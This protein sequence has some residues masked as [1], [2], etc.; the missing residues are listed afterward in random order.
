MLSGHES[1]CTIPREKIV[2][3]VLRHAQMGNRIIEDH[4]SLLDDE[5][6]SNKVGGSAPTSCFHFVFQ[7]SIFSGVSGVKGMYILYIYLLK[8]V[9]IHLGH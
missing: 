6:M 9:R 4:V 1:R 8:F 3:A 2:W 7:A 5:Q